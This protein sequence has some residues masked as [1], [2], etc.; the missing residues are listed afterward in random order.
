[1]WVRKTTPLGVIVFGR[2]EFRG[3]IE[4]GVVVG[5]CSGRRNWCYESLKCEY[6]TDMFE[7]WIVEK[8][9]SEP[10]DIETISENIQS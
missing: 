4:A 1:M 8:T 10:V 7:T 3:W 2:L 9:K 6:G 5:D